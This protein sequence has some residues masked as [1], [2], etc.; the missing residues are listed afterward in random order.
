MLQCLTVLS[1]LL[2]SI[3]FTTTNV[4]RAQAYPTQPIKMYKNIK[5]LIAFAKANPGKLTYASAGTGT[6]SFLAG[7]MFK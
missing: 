5:E 7:E 2:I 4:A 6:A 3:F 1:S